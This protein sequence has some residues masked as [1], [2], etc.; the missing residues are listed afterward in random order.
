MGATSADTVCSIR[1][2]WQVPFEAFVKWWKYKKQEYRRDLK[3]RVSTV[4]RLVDV[5]GSGELS[6]KEV[7]KMYR[8][9]ARPCCLSALL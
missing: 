5:D 4:F 3:N 7:A 2:H 6:K 1:A 8:A 9:V